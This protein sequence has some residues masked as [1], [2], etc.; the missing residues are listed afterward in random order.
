M[1]GMCLGLLVM[2]K[3]MISVAN[4]IPNIKPIM[5][6]LPITDSVNNRIS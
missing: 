4:R 5:I 3:P 2:I 6:G 1:V